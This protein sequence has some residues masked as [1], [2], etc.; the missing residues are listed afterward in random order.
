MAKIKYCLIWNEWCLNT[1]CYLGGLSSLITIII[2]IIMVLETSVLSWRPI[3]CTRSSPNSSW[4]GKNSFTFSAKVQPVSPKPHLAISK[5]FSHTLDLKCH[6]QIHLYFYFS[7]PLYTI[8]RMFVS[9]YMQE[10]ERTFAHITLAQCSL[11]HLQILTWK[12]KL[13]QS[14]CDFRCAIFIIISTACI[15]IFGTV[16]D[17]EVRRRGERGFDLIVSPASQPLY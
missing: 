15:L 11:A 13:A 2:V 7:L 5:V 3:I 17:D 10:Q 4:R 16:T 9:I 8:A 1:V 14:I 6:L 12:G